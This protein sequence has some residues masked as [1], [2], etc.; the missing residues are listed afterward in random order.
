MSLL[1]PAGHDP[2]DAASLPKDDTTHLNYRT[3]PMSPRDE[4]RLSLLILVATLPVLLVT[5]S[6]FAW[7]G[8]LHSVVWNL[9]GAAMVWLVIRLAFY[10][11]MGVS[12]RADLIGTGI[13][14]VGIGMV[15]VRRLIVVMEEWDVVLGVGLSWFV[16][17]IMARQVASWIL[18]SPLVSRQ[19]AERWKSSL[20]TLWWQG[21]SIECPDLLT[22]HL[23]PIL[24]ATA[25]WVAKVFAVEVADTPWIWPL[26]FPIL[27]HTL[28]W[29]YHGTGVVPKTDPW[30]CLRLTWKGVVVFLTYDLRQTK[31]A[32]VFRF[33][34]RWLRP[35][36]VRWVFVLVPL[37][38]VGMG[39]EIRLDDWL[40]ANGIKGRALRFLLELGFA[41]VAAPLVL[42]AV[43]WGT[44][45]TLL[46]R[47]H[48]CL[49]VSPDEKKADSVAWDN[50]VD[51]LMNSVDEQQ[52]GR[53][54][55]FL[56]VTL[57][58][59]Y[60][61]L[62]DRR[63]VDQHM[64]IVGDTG[65]SKTSLG[66]AP[67]S[68]QLIGRRDCGVVVVDLKGDRALFQTCAI[69]AERAG[70]PF[71]W[72]CSEVGHTT[73]GY[74]PFLQRHNQQ[75][76]SSQ[77][78]QEIL[79]G[80]S[81]DYGVGYGAGYF[82]AMNE[83]VL[84]KLMRHRSVR[85]FRELSKLLE[86]PSTY[87]TIGREEDWKQARHLAAIVDRLAEGESFNITPGIM[88]DRPEVHAKAIDVSD[89][90]E[91][92]Q[93]VYLWLRSA[94]EPISAPSIARL[95][96]W[97]LFTA[98]SH[99]ASVNQRVYI[100]IDE[101]QQII[102]DGV[103]LIFEQFRDIGGTIIA[104]HQTGGQL[105]RHGTDLSE[106]I[107]SC[108]AVK[109]IYRASD[110]RTLKMLEELSGTQ[111]EFLPGWYQSW[112]TGTGDI[113]DRVHVDHADEGVVKVAGRE[114]PI[115]DRRELMRISSGDLTSI[116][117]FTMASGFT[118]FGGSL[119]PIRSMYP[120]D[121]DE[122]QLRKGLPW[123]TDPGAF[124]VRLPQSSSK[125]TIASGPAPAPTG[126]PPSGPSSVSAP[127]DWNTII[128]K[129]KAGE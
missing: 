15:F 119:V 79:Q 19:T 50:Y 55:L 110:P 123:P 103:K 128:S 74:N 36:W 9:F 22:F 6:T 70:I 109:H 116:V 80:L 127:D 117:R 37:V 44:A 72:L 99:H 108:T 17:V 94:Q 2:L 101:A 10:R 20:P 47:F 69:E 71:R 96:L 113:L 126:A 62:V 82:T 8:S 98:G 81:L 86:H 18:A 16:S 25:A 64:H 107:D 31:A 35:P 90:F 52:K 57:S 83:I 51:R 21:M 118:Q 11:L 124:E 77:V 54:H 14:A 24:L 129:R 49:D 76:T 46:H 23:A 56:G 78:A 66:V 40:V 122:Y 3:R 105:R 121:F 1:Q 95:F 73:F 42:L 100:F 61:V 28:L 65:S 125:T 58:G 26:V 115:L 33:P 112:E 85:S 75:M 12:I 39:I 27:L 111:T 53:D 91:R 120:I 34:S 106:T 104:A 41:S 93:V 5:E 63:I 84:T 60:P 13:L 30:E 59:D 45:S 67:L 87:K 29:F 88:P 68:T 114:R 92:P 7:L 38:V 43:F 4:Q 102:S 89:L 48:Q 32:G 97:S